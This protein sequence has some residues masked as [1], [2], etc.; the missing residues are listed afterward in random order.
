MRER[1]IVGILLAAGFSRRYGA[2]KL[3]QRLPDGTFVAVAAARNL[4]A[5]L[6]GAI[7]VTRPGVPELERALVEVGLSVTVCPDAELGMGS[8]L[9]HAVRFAGPAAGY[10]VALADMPFIQNASITGVAEA[11]RAGASVAAPRYAGERGHPVG[12]SGRHYAELV[13]ISGDDGAKHIVKREQLVWVNCPDP[14]V[15]RD[16]D[17]PADLPR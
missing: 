14:G 15:V 1:A 16:I 3:L 5:A 13:T 11:L 10:V 17:T 9:A 12:L 7:A 6:P 8:S 4:L 2:N